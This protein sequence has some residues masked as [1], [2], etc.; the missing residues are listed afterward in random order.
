M[1]SMS[2][3]GFAD[4]PGVFRLMTLRLNDQ[5]NTTIYG[6]EDRLRDASGSRDIVFMNPEDVSQCSLSDG[7]IVVFHSG[8]R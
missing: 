1:S 2:S 6:Y 3:T 7:G 5:F 8:R 4:G